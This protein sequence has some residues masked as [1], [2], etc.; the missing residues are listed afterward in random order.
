MEK[1]TQLTLISKSYH[2]FLEDRRNV[3]NADH[4]A[5]CIGNSHLII[6]D[7]Y[8]QRSKDYEFSWANIISKDNSAY[9]C[10]YAHARLHR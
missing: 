10:H 6:S 8:K 9:M 4:V 1:K 5:Q 2:V 7:F 3:E